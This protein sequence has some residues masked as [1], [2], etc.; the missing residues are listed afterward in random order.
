MN[1]RQRI[2]ELSIRDR[3]TLGLKIALLFIALVAAMIGHPPSNAQAPTPWTTVPVS[4]ED[5]KQDGDIA[6]MKASIDSDKA[7]LKEL[8]ATVIKQGNDLASQ[9]TKQTFFFWLIC[10]IVSG[11]IGLQVYSGPKNKKDE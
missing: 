4:G 9:D 2:S 1:L 11:Q 3:I 7:A 10:A 8:T 6:Y 5:I